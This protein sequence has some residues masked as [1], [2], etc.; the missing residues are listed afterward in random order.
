[1]SSGSA[2]VLVWLVRGYVRHVPGSLGKALLTELFLNPQLRETPSQVTAKSRFGARFVVDTQDLI[3]RYLYMFGVWE[4]HMTR[5]LQ[6]RLLPGDT[7]IDVGAN[8]GY[9]TVLAS[10]LVGEGGR[11][12]AVEASPD[13]HQRLLEQVRLNRRDNVRAVN[14]AVSDERRTLT[15]V[16]ASSANMGANSIVPY[17]GPV[18]SSFEVEAFPLGELLTP[19]EISTARVIKIDVEGAEGSVVRGMVPLL[20][21]LRPDCEITVE[22]TPDRMTQLGDSAEELMQT[23]QEHGF[24]AYRLANEYTPESYVTALRGKRAIPVRWRGPVVEES[25]L[26]FSRVDAETLP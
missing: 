15:F 20:D 22:V 9:Y 2:K 21:K 19:E 24:H 12:V 25:D 13:F 6:A 5:W 18:E 10:G 14:G 11:V 7:F 26:I 17:D 23:M 3:Q 4:P 16:L 1:M 8:I